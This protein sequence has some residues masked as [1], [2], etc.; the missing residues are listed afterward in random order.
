MSDTIDIAAGE[1]HRDGGGLSGRQQWR[2]NIRGKPARNLAYRVGVG[3]VGTIVLLVGVVA[4][5]YPGPGWL[6]VLAGLA[7]LASEFERARNALSFVTYRYHRWTRWLSRQT[8]AVQGLIV[9]ATSAVV[10]ITLWLLGTLNLV[11]GWVGWHASW[12]ASPILG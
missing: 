11:A 12:L 1:P 4:I 9:L 10:L 7:I 5:P 3:V 8:Y 2:E 6:I